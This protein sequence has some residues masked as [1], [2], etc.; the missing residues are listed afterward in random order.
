MFSFEAEIQPQNFSNNIQECARNESEPI[1]KKFFPI[2]GINS[3]IFRI[4]CFRMAPEMMIVKSNPNVSHW[5][6]DGGYAK[7]VIERGYPV[8]VFNA[9]QDAALIIYLKLF[10]ED[11]EYICRGPIQGFKVILNTPGQTLKI[12]R[13]AFRVPLSEQAE[14]SIKPTL[15][16]TANALVKYS[17]DQRKCFFGAERQLRFFKYYA[18]HNCE[19][20]CLANFTLV[21][22]G[23]VKFHMPSI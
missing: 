5:S 2:F 4:I 6:L 23:C 20:E 8:R 10:Q 15:I 3:L 9:R 17:P 11:L 1:Q 18:Q 13:H 22:C 14:I 21:E 19:A 16:T 12:S 7:G